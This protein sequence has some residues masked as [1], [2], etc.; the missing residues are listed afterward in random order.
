MRVVQLL[1][2][3]NAGGVETGTL[4]TARS[5]DQAGHESI[6]ISAGGRLVKS[7]EADGSRHILLPVHKKRLGSPQQVKAL[8]TF[9]ETERPDVLHLRS[10][11][12]AWLVRR[13]MSPQTRPR[14]VSTVHEFYSVNT[15]SKIMTCGEV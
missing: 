1:L 5:L 7:L 14:I 3:L 4:E 13:K 8:R 10:R 15:Y 12:P 11:L 6:V 9:F 2:E